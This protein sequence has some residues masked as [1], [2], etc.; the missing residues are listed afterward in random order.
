MTDVEALRRRV[1][2]LRLCIEQQDEAK[3]RLE[4]RLTDLERKYEWAH[5]LAWLF[6]S[7]SVA[8]AGLILLSIWG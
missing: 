1:A 4:N 6:G 3:Q 7:F 8:F 5:G 2:V